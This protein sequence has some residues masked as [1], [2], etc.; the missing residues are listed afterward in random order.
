[1]SRC[2]LDLWPVVLESSWYNKRHVL[3][4]CMK[5]ER[6]R[7]IRGWI[8]DNFA[9][10]CTRYV[11]LGPWPLTSWLWTFTARRVS[12]VSNLYKFVRNRI[13]IGWVIDNLSRF[14]RAILWGRAQLTRCFSG[15]RGRG[16]Q[17]SRRRRGI[18]A[19]LHLWLKVRI[20]CCIFKRR[21]LKNKW[22]WQRREISHFDPF[23]LWK[24]GEGWQ[25]FD[26]HPL[27]GC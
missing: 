7:A 19:A 12:Y 10:F 17:T 22:C 3:K 26:G 21:R 14:R 18:I 23:P 4:V 24:L 13:I 20:S 16:Q 5:L 11:R 9:N 15:V 27:R 6:N 1:M 25:K 8:M 2:D